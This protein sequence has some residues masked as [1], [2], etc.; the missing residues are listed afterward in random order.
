MNYP[1]MVVNLDESA[2]STR[3]REGLDGKEAQQG[4]DFPCLAQKP[5][6]G[7]RMAGEWLSPVV[8]WKAPELRPSKRVEERPKEGAG[9]AKAEELSLKAVTPPR[10]PLRPEALP[11]R[12]AANATCSC[13]S[14]D[15]YAPCWGY[16]RVDIEPTN[17]APPKKQ[18]KKKPP[19]QTRKKAVPVEI[20]N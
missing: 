13:P 2:V 8:S 19:T 3:V 14:T 6:A 10:P 12:R 15:P 20:K 17:S 1:E 16:W 18:P 9:E 11:H 4:A 5:Q 7:I